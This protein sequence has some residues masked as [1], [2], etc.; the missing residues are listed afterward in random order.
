MAL[1]T[2]LARSSLM[3]AVRSKDTKPELIVRSIAHRLGARFRLHRKDL[4]GSPDLVFPGRRLC[5]FVHG[6]FWHRHEGCRYSSIPKNNKEF[7]LDK[8]RKNVERDNRKM[9]EL[10]G[11]GWRVEIIWECET[12][13]RSVL[14]SRLID[15]LGV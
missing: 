14:E 3:R 1:V 7:W 5:I 9:L 11:M 8:F 12:H 15:V 13:N 4:P 6:C 2:S 10:I